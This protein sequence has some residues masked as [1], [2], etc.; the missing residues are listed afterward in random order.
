MQKFILTSKEDIQKLKE[1]QNLECKLAIGKD[2]KGALPHDFWET[3]SAFANTYGGTILLGVREKKGE[4]FLSSLENPERIKSDLFATLN[5]PKKVSINLLQDKD[6]QEFNIEGAKI[7]AI[8]VPQAP[9]QQ[10]PVYLNNNPLGHT[11]RRLHEG[12]ICCSDDVVKRML[13]EQMEESLDGDILEG[14]TMEDLSLHTIDAYRHYFSIYKPDH[15]WNALNI[16]EFLKSIGAWKRNRYTDIEGISRA[17]ILMFG[18]QEAI[19][20]AFSFYFL[21]YREIPQK[22]DFDTRWLD[23]ITLDGSWSGNL[24]DF[25]RKVILKLSE[26]LKIPFEIEKNKR[27]GDSLQHR[28]LREALINTLVHADYLGRAPILIEKYID[29]FLFKNPGLLR[30]SIEIAFEG[31][32]SDC[33]NR[34][35]HQMFSYI[36]LGERAGSGLP[37]I[38]QAWNLCSFQ[39]DL[40]E[41]LDPYD[42]TI[43]KIW[44]NAGKEGANA[45]KEGANA[46][47]EGANAGKEEFSSHIDKSTLN[48][49]QK[50]ILVCIEKNPKAK[51][52]EIALYLDKDKRTIERNI[53]KLQDALIL[54]RKGGRKEGEWEIL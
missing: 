25:Y 53:K 43:L 27:I 6:I 44:K 30:I 20:N 1:G 42:Q 8:S 28:A 38:K 22:D 9:R 19:L 37:K 51:I 7:L 50:E 16:K 45:G 26:N 5:N 15:P 36:G 14:F 48:I 39:V 17:G 47:K 23:R 21:D 13:A 29:G 10:K 52:L 2:G 24:F 31:G 49:I 41:I 54:K 34:I 40:Y 35:L 18:N 33:R 3:Y 11:Y 4:F 12:D 46:G 32:E